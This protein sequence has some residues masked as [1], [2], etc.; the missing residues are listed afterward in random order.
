MRKSIA[1][2]AIGLATLAG[3]L[4]GCGG[5]DD[6]AADT[7]SATAPATDPATAPAP[8]GD[9]EAVRASAAERFL[10]ALETHGETLDATGSDLNDAL[11]AEDRTR[12]AATI[13]DYAAAIAAYD[14]DVRD[15][16]VPADAEDA[17]RR[18]LSADEAAIAAAAEVERALDAG[19]DEA[20]LAALADFNE[21]DSAA[22]AASREVRTLL[23]RSDP[24]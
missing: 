2:G 15:I 8:G 5:D 9:Q 20:T 11:E 13:A 19:D 1:I 6:P 12:I 17:H 4:A 16:A 24:S 14:A 18:L 10:T 3:G 7:V 21:A 22:I 23:V